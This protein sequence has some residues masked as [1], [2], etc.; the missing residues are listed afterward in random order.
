MLAFH[1]TVV[2][3]GAWWVLLGSVLAGVLMGMV[4][5]AMHADRQTNAP[6]DPVAL[7]C[8]R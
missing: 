3:P 1:V 6:R 2:L 4:R 7:H 5:I 8:L